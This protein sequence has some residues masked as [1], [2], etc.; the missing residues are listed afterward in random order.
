MSDL[1]TNRVTTTGTGIEEIETENV[2]GTG[3]GT[4]GTETTGEETRTEMSA[5]VEKHDGTTDDLALVLGIEENETAR[6][7]GSRPLPASRKSRNQ[8]LRRLQ[9]RR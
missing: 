1:V 5:T 7:I 6:E 2:R 9:L 4:K 8:L 3:I